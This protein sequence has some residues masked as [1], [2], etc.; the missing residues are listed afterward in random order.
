MLT[1]PPA[2]ADAAAARQ[3]AAANQTWTLTL[4]IGPARQIKQRYGIDLPAAWR[5]NWAGLDALLADVWTFLDVLWHL[6]EP[7]AKERNVD[8]AAFEASLDEAATTAAADALRAA[9]V[10]FIPAALRGQIRAAGRLI[11]LADD[12]VTRR[13]Q[14]PKTA[15]EIDSLVDAELSR[16]LAAV[17]T[18]AASPPSGP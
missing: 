9:I 7:A 16:R 15:Q 17:G 5:D 14:N 3:F 13:V 18:D 1:T 11:D 2:P 4:T 8:R 6:V 10:G 12:A